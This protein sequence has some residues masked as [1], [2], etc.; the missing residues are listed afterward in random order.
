MTDFFR[1]KFNRAD[2][3]IGDNYTIPCGGVIVVD[4]ESVIP[5]DGTVVESGVSPLFVPGTTAVKTQ[6]LYT[7]E[8]MDGPDQQVR[9]IWAHDESD[10]TVIQG[11]STDP[12]LT[13]LA[14]MGKDPLLYDLGTAEDPACYDQ[15]YG[16]RV[17]MPRDGTAPILKIVKFM[18]VMR[19]PGI[20]RPSSTEVDG[21]VVLASITLADVDLNLDPTYDSDTDTLLPYRG[22]WQD[23]RLRIRRSDNE[24]ILDVYLNDRNMN[25]AVLSYTDKADPLWG[26][27]GYPG[28]EFLGATLSSQPAGVSPFSLAGLSTLRVGQFQVQTVKDLRRPVTLQPGNMMTYLEVT[29]RVITLAEKNGDARYNATVSGSTKFATYL[30][31]VF[32][33]ETDIIKEQGHWEFLR[34]EQ[35]IY[36]TDGVAEYEVPINCGRVTEIRPTWNSPPLESLDPSI[37]YRRFGPAT[38]ASGNPVAYSMVGM[39]PDDRQI[40]R[41]FPIPQIAEGSELAIWI[42]YFARALR[43]DPAEADVLIPL[44][45]QEHMDV[46]VYGAAAH[47][48]LLN[49]DD[50]DVQRFSMIYAA[51]LGKM[52]RDDNRRPTRTIARSAA[53]LLDPVRQTRLPLTRT[54]QLENSI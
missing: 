10:E 17:T 24:V 29:N 48:L 53:D 26:D 20:S 4:N 12:S 13:L 44:I 45:P 43:P 35:Q 5:I 6:V 7:D 40:F 49:T 41:L 2:G 54:G 14:R 1:D 37:L 22:F 47:S 25:T 9:M 33:A 39:G 32:E 8:D 36:L 19:I 11:V 38:Q 34:R 50:A 51:K 28:F 23:M 16:A 21:M 46:L 27:V 42:D 18:P 3:A 52:K 30:G 31:F 15:G